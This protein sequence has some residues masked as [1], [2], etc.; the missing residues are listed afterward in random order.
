M[1]AIESAPLRVYLVE[2]DNDLREDMVLLLGSAGFDVRGLPDAPSFYKAH[3]LAPCEVAVLDVGLRGED[4]LSVASAL[5]SSG[6][7]GIVMASARGDVEDRIEALRRGADVYMTKPVHIE[8]L[9]ATIR[10][11]GSRVRTAMRPPPVRVPTAPPQR[12][13]WQ[14]AE[15]G[16][17]LCDPAGRALK[18]TNNERA[19][20]STLM[21]QNGQVVSRD[22]LLASLDGQAGDTDPKKLDVI[23]SRLRRKSEQADMRLPLHV[24]RG[25]GYQFFQ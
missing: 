22:A 5:R 11:L 25:I 14:L 24:V 4:G 7:I 19:F 18:L 17:L 12:P 1:T 10:M 2:D 20:V 15:G 16:W 13:R 9:A 23:A 6:P 8:E 21:A 3:A